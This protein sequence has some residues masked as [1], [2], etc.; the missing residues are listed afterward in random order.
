MADSI[1]PRTA[2]TDAE[3]RAATPV[4]LL[5][6]PLI[7]R[8]L[9]SYAFRVAVQAILTVWLVLTSTFFLIRLLPASPM[10]VYVEDLMR[11]KDYTREQAM[12]KASIMFSTDL[13]LPVGQQYLLYLNNV[14]HGNLG[15]S[16][17]SAGTS[18]AQLIASFLPWTLFSVGIALLISFVSGLGLGMLMAYWRNSL[19]DTVMTTFTSFLSSVPSYLIAIEIV[20]ILGVQMKVL[21]VGAARGAYSPGIAPA[22]TPE[23][24]LDIVSHAALPILTYLLSTFGSWT[25][26]MKNSTLG[27]LGEE[28]VT[29]AHARGLGRGRIV[30]AYVGRNASLPMFTQLALS[31]GFVVGGSVIIERYFL[32]PGIGLK[33][34]TAIHDRDYPVMQGVFIVIT[35]TVIVANLLTD[36]LYGQLD[37]RVRVAKQ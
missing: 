22:F 25:L 4:R 21:S 15:T 14:L 36:F 23:F 18:V 19:F 8:L 10:D 9:R 11:T 33:L 27:V 31:I 17:K 26:S 29:A 6:V 13:S 1:V 32:Y 5:I 30:L 2:V 20:Y 28:Y 37:P 7:G 24:I 35:T 16:I 3:L 34:F 12:A